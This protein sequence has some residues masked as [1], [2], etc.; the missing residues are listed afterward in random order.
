[1]NSY[2]YTYTCVDIHIENRFWKLLGNSETLWVD[3]GSR[4]LTY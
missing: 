1:M 2:I 4:D 3:R